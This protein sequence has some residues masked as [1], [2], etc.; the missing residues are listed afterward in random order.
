MGQAEWGWAGKNNLGETGWVGETTASSHQRRR[1]CSSV[2]GAVKVHKG[3]LKHPELQIAFSAS[4]LTSKNYQ[5]IFGEF[6]KRC[7][8]K[9]NK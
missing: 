3:N 2:K 9:K 7:D 8:T 1:H 4:S 6:E 5:K